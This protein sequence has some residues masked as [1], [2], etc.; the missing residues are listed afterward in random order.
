MA[1]MSGKA[2]PGGHG[3]GH[4][5]RAVGKAPGKAQH[6]QRQTDNTHRLVLGHQRQ[7]LAKAFG[8]ADA[9]RPGALK[10]DQGDD[11]PAKELAYGPPGLGGIAYGHLHGT[12]SPELWVD[13]L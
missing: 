5:R 12:R 1:G 2:L 11:E 6:R 9:A 7:A 13:G 8:V 10:H 3:F 4:G